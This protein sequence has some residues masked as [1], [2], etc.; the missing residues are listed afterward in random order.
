MMCPNCENEAPDDAALCPTCEAVLD[1]SLLAPSPKAARAPARPVAR[2]VTRKPGEGSRAPAGKRPPTGQ[3]P[4]AARPKPAAEPEPDPTPPRAKAPKEDWRSKVSKED[5]EQMPQGKKEEFVVDKA[6]D[7]EDFLADVK[8]LVLYELSNADKLALFGAVG[9]VL[10]CFFPWKD[11]VPEGEVLG[12]MSGGIVTLLMSVAA[13]T[14]IVIRVRKV[15]GKMSPL[16]PW[17][18][19]LSCIGGATLWA[20]V[21][22]RNAINTTTVRA[23][24]G[25]A[26][27]W[28]SKPGFGVFLAMVAGVVGAIGTVMGL[29]ETRL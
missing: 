25:N 12:L 13:I 11:A 20:L 17:V 27:V 5:W 3:R 24:I 9:M 7:P 29:K 1:E 22:M 23:P 14:A 8:K 15:M 21:S 19:Q 28:A 2:K 18:G 6:M 4:A 26:E 16:V 10:A